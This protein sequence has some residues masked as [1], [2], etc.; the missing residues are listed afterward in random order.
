MSCSLKKWFCDLPWMQQGVLLG[1][2]R[3][4]DGVKSEGPHKVL[5]RGIRGTCVKSA[6]TKMQ[7]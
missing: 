3:N 5:V 7:F 1:A 2:I 4:Y 6:K